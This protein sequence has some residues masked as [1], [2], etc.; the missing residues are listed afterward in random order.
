M[1][2]ITRETDYAMLIMCEIALST[3]SQNE[4]IS[5]SQLSVKTNI[6]IPTVSKLLKLLVKS[7]I[8]SSTRGPN[9]GYQLIKEAR[10]VNV[11]DIICAIEGPVSIN[12]CATGEYVCDR[13]QVCTL[14]PHWVKINETVFTALSSVLLSDLMLPATK[15]L[16][17]NEQKKIVEHKVLIKNISIRE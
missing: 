16:H 12:N 1:L 3:A 14:A 9:G 17:V 11:A 5:A 8:L 6:S 13:S 2:K 10:Q 15:T 4:S 7:G